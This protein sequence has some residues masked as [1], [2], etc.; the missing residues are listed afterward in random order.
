MNARVAALLSFV[1]LTGALA[2][3][4]D[5]NDLHRPATLERDCCRA[6]SAGER[7]R[8]VARPGWL[9]DRQQALEQV[10]QAGVREQEA[11]FETLRGELSGARSEWLEQAED[12]MSGLVERRAELSA[13]RKE[14]RR[15]R[16]EAERAA[17]AIDERIE[18]LEELEETLEEAAEEIG[19]AIEEAA[20]A[21]EDWAQELEQVLED[22]AE[23]FE[24][25]LEEMAE[26]LEESAEELVEAFE[27][28]LEIDDC[29]D[30]EDCNDCRDEGRCLDCEDCGDND[31]DVDRARP[32]PSKEMDWLSGDELR[33]PDELARAL[34]EL[35]R[36][37]GDLRSDLGGLRRDVVFPESER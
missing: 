16:R 25:Q 3:A 18:A 21:R 22:A 13:A 11:A 10:F 12:Q 34:L 35:R 14:V 17:Q 5:S 7:A 26:A 4:Q 27:R 36:E 29:G 24:E 8:V 6:E 37:V 31:C 28:A 9:G 20:E 23:C 2:L 32:V 15:A 33:D 30:C 19:D 1:G